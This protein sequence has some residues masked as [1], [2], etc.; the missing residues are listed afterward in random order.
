MRTEVGLTC[1]TL[2]SRRNVFYTQNA[3]TTTPANETIQ[4]EG[5]SRRRE[6]LLAAAHES[7]YQGRSEMR[8]MVGQT[9]L[10]ILC[11]HVNYFQMVLGYGSRFNIT[12]TTRKI[13]LLLLQSSIV[14][15]RYSEERANTFCLQF[16]SSFTSW[17]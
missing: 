12:L 9:I 15:T 6:E 2:R 17:T 5:M 13:C 10:L 3:I 4:I 1:P 8:M 16:L 11:Q 14:E 7:R